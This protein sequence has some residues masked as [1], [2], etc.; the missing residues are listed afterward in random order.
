M[1]T[2]RRIFVPVICVVTDLATV[3]QV[4]FTGDADLTVVPTDIVRDLALGAGIPAEKVE[5]IGIPVHPSISAAGGAGKKK[6]RAELGWRPDTTTLLAVG[7]KRVGGLSRVLDAFN[8]SGLRL[9]IA[10]VAGGDDELYQELSSREWHLPAKIY[11]FVDNMPSLMRASDFVVA[12]AGG[13]IVTECLA[14]GL[15]MLF[16]D[17][18]PGQETG[19][20]DYAVAGGAAE[21]AAD[22]VAALEIVY[23]WL[24]DGKRKLSEHAAGAKALGRPRAAFDIIERAWEMAVLKPDKRDLAVAVDKIKEI[25]GLFNENYED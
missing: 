5:V 2:L 20:A 9:Q 11:N 17:M 19:N 18:I 6:L 15:P 7:S 23:H 22:P 16:V 24:S 4:W 14:A 12:K 3:H 25:F 21:I 13:L 10:A 8:H 1:F